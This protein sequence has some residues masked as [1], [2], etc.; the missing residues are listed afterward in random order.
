MFRKTFCLS[1]L[2]ALLV[3]Y[4]VTPSTR[5]RADSPADE[6]Q[7]ALKQL[8][9]TLKRYQENIE[10]VQRLKKELTDAAEKAAQAKALVEKLQKE[11][12]KLRQD[13]AVARQQLDKALK[14]QQEQIEKLQK[15]DQDLARLQGKAGRPPEKDSRPPI[16]GKVKEVQQTGSIILSIGSDAGL[17]KGDKLEVYRL[18]PKPLYLGQIEITELKATEA[19]ARRIGMLRDT[20]RAGDEASTQIP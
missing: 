9:D 1:I 8:E 15:L 6:A 20:V 12:E 13:A 3:S 2:A 14:L 18:K 19:V 11:G 17:K 10:N 4:A 5:A 7:R 16:Q